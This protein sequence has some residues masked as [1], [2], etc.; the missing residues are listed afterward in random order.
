MSV[1]DLRSSF[2]TL[3][4][5]RNCATHPAT[6]LHSAEWARDSLWSCGVQGGDAHTVSGH[7][8]SATGTTHIWLWEPQFAP[9]EVWLAQESPIPRS[10]LVS[11]L[12]TSVNKESVLDKGQALLTLDTVTIP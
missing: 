7:W 2:Q 9:L 3:R 5:S 8:H 10:L 12:C 4:P 6:S 1:S 11:L